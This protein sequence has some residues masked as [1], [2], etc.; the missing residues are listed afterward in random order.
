LD[1]APPRRPFHPLVNLG[2]L[3]ITGVTTLIAGALMASSDP[4]SGSALKH[5]LGHPAEWGAGWPYASAVLLILGAHEMGHYIACRLYR[6]DAS[7]PFFLPGPNLFGTF[8]AVI[9][10]RAPFTDRKALFDVGVAGPIAGFVVALPVLYYGLVHSTVSAEAPRSGDVALTSCLLLNW[11]Y[12]HFFSAGSD[13]SIHLHPTFAA[14][15][16]GLF[17]TS[18]NLLPI[19][20]LDGGHM[21]FALSPRVHRI[22]SRAGI[23]LLCGGG[24]LSGGYHLVLFGVLFAILGV[25][26]PRPIDDITPLGP[27]RVALAILGALIFLVCFF[28]TTPQPL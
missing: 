21:L 26:H 18:L 7:L 23:P 22:V 17:A 24:W 27:G 28:P 3:M 4:I 6:I 2:C 1:S 25:R 19:G 11:L 16:L 14:A 13:V 8:G 10:I 15:W 12:P 20:Q 9:R 5:L